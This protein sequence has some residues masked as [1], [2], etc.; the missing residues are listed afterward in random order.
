MSE[1]KRQ[2]RRSANETEKTRLLILKVATCL[3]AKYGFTRVSLRNISEKAGISH[4]LI[5]HHFGS[6]EQI[7]YS[8]SDEIHQVMEH[9]CV[10]SLKT[11]DQ[12][13]PANQLFYQYSLKMLALLLKYPQPIQLMAD[14]MREEG[15]LRDY[16]MDRKGSVEQIHQTV[17]T[18]YNEQNPD[19]QIYPK[20]I[21][22]MVVMFSHSAASL[23][24]FMRDIWDEE[25]LTD[26]EL[27]FKHWELYND[28]A[29]MRLRVPEEQKLYPNS[30]D[31]LLADFMH[32]RENPFI[33][34]CF[35][36]D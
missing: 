17:T 27:I 25:Q 35:C 8:I 23:V 19:A 20:E 14:V 15:E 33:D 6:K 21:K 29:A 22:W 4:S 16:L 2:G 32:S 36:H 10:H 11:L 12:S 7:W 24:P 30:L 26:E 18:L 31:E 9:Y 1:V 13:L 34:G 5:R 3:F 28:L